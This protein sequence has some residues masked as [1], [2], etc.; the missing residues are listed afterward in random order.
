L[1]Q[2]QVSDQVDPHCGFS[3]PSI[4]AA[5]FMDKPLLLLVDDS[6]DM[7]VVVR[8]LSKR[9]GVEVEHCSSVADGWA[10]L[11]RRTPDLLLLDMILTG[12]TGVD[13]CRRLRATPQVAAMRVALFTISGLHENLRAGLEAGADVVFAKD[14]VVQPDDWRRRL[15]EILAWSRGRVWTN[16]VAWKTDHAWPAP[17]PDWLGVYNQALRQGLAR[18]MSGS[19]LRVLVQRAINQTC[20][21]ERRGDEGHAW[22]HVTDAALNE[23]HLAPLATPETVAFLGASLAEQMWC[24]LG[25]RDSEFFTA[26]LAPVVPGLTEALTF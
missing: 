20:A 18:G 13:L 7:A 5:A 16:L 3:L 12:E 1:L 26:A 17:P 22:L 21:H 2:L 25:S 23:A 19:L 4:A 14:L 15:A 6:P 24:L 8:L 11:Q 10:A 9:A